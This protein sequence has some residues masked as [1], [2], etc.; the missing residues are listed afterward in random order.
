MTTVGAGSAREQ[1]CHRLFA[2][3]GR[4]Y[5]SYHAIR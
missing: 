4:S 3:E 1:M 2:A 5:N